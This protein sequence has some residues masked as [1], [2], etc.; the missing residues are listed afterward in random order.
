MGGPDGRSA[1]PSGFVLSPH[2]LL[3]T[4]SQEFADNSNVSKYI[5]WLKEKNIAEVADYQELWQWSV[6][7]V[8]A[9]WASL[10][11]Y[12][13]ILSD[14][15]YTKVTDSLEMKP[16]NRWFIGSKVNLAEHILRNERAGLMTDVREV[17]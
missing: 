1:S 10:W 11:D 13:D 6:D 8:E 12:F 3:W 16:G 17:L 5:V 15:P 9:F 4:P 7:N 14:T 2:P